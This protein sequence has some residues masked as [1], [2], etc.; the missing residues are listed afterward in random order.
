[1]LEALIYTALIVLGVAS[2]TQLKLADNGGIALMQ[3]IQ[4][5]FGT[6]GSILN[7]ILVILDV[8]TTAVGL[9][10]SFA[11]DMHLIF[12][13]SSYN[14]WLIISSAG[15][16]LTANLGLTNIIKCHHRY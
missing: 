10:F 14:S 6:S 5:Y 13:K 9:L 12:N 16:F 2:L 8:F 1:M 4:H 3:I 11:Q 15:S 7:G